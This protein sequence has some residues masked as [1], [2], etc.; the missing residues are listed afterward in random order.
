MEFLPPEFSARA[1]DNTNLTDLGCDI[2]FMKGGTITTYG[3]L[4]GKGHQLYTPIVDEAIEESEDE[5]QDD[6]ESESEDMGMG[7]MT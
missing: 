7:G 1:L 6:T 2:L 5:V 3:A 4:S